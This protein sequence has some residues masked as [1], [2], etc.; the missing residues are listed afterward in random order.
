VVATLVAVDGVA[1]DFFGASLQLYEKTLV[2]G[3]KVVSQTGG[4]LF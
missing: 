4:K 2:V 1:N 3:S